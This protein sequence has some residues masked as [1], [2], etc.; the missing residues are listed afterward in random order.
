M[1]STLKI[2]LKLGAF[3]SE[4]SLEY[5]AQKQSLGWKV[6]TSCMS[7]AVEVQPALAAQFSAAFLAQ[8]AGVGIN[9]PSA[10]PSAAPG[11]LFETK[12]NVPV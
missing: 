8:A 5:A 3:E 4:A 7:A 10:S 12:K 11:E 9:S 1:F 2:V 6:D